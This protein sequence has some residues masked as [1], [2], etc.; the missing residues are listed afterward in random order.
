MLQHDQFLSLLSENTELAQGVFRTLLAS[1]G[2]WSDSLVTRNAIRPSTLATPGDG[3]QMI[4]KVLVLAEMPVLA[5]ASAEQLSALAAITKEVPLTVGDVFVAPGDAPAVH[6]LLEGALT[7]EPLDGRPAETA[8][9]GDCTGLYET[10]RGSRETS[11]RGQVTQPGV[12][13]R[14]ERE[15]LFDLL[16]DQ[17]DLLQALF[18]AIQRR[19]AQQEP[20]APAAAGL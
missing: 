1:P 5:R 18:S 14:I 7:L 15:A 17:I 13:L 10:L 11:W 19:P 16:A 12:A 3:L 9:A 8:G 2:G 4:E 6:I 20:V